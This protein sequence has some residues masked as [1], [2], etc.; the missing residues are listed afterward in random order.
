MLR[1]PAAR[2]AGAAPP[3]SLPTRGAKPFFFFCSNF[4][5]HVFSRSGVAF[6]FVIYFGFIKHQFRFLHGFVRRFCAVFER[7]TLEVFL[8]GVDLSEDGLAVFGDLSSKPV[9]SRD[10]ALHVRV[11]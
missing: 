5:H 3:R 6:F 8:V 10:G 2:K 11:R 1:R 4:F 7:A 9:R